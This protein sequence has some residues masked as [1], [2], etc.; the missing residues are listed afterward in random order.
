MKWILFFLL[1][2]GGCFFG[3]RHYINDQIKKETIQLKA[4]MQKELD[5]PQV[6]P[7]RLANPLNSKNMKGYLYR[8][9]RDFTPAVH[10]SALELLYRMGDPIV[11]AAIKQSF[12]KDGNTSLKLKM[13]DVFAEYQDKETI[14][15]LSVAL[16][17][18]DRG[19]RLKSVDVLSKY[20][21]QQA[22]DVLN[23]TMSSTD[24]E[25]KLKARDVTRQISGSI[26]MIRADY[27]KKIQEVNRGFG[28]LP[29]KYDS[30]YD[31]KLRQM[32]K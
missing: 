29:N 5:I 21:C 15:L 6:A 8:T 25:L 13:L 17:D 11:G 12:Q 22:I 4:E 3:F 2:V 9:A 7:E 23:S 30:D 16:K 32:A 20:T 31:K 28:I 18:G 26:A 1:I 27:D 24:L 10:W 14:D 19:V